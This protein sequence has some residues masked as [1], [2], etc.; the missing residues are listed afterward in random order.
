M[1]KR[2]RKANFSNAE[3]RVLL[4]EVGL[5]KTTLSSCFSNGV[6]NCKKRPIWAEFQVKVNTCCV[7]HRSVADFKEK[8]VALKRS[9]KDRLK[10]QKVMGGGQPLPTVDFEN[11]IY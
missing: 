5:E 2:S 9:M 10:D 8:W 3:T 7:A 11:V 6:S 4:E 1:S